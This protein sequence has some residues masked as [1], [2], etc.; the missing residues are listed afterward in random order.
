MSSKSLCAW[1]RAAVI[2]AAVCGSVLCLGILPDWGRQIV[3]ENPNMENWFLPWLIFLWAAALPC[4]AILVF[5]WKV[6]G[7]IAREEVF[8]LRTAKRIK[9]AAGLL[10]ADAGFFF[11][12]NLALLL[13]NMSHPFVLFLSIFADIFA[14]AAAILAATLSRYITK[15]AALQEESEGTI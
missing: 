1:V 13:L 2:A 3:A 14:V 10:F 7:A 5:V 15:A 8:T 4:F 9:T 6:S 12:G 11:A